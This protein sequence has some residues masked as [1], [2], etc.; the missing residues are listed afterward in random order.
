MI[1]SSKP[2]KSKAAEIRGSRD[3]PACILPSQD[4]VNSMR[5][6]EYTPYKEML[7]GVGLFSLEKRQIGGNL[8]PFYNY[9]KGG[10]DEVGVALFSHV[11]SNR[12]RGNGFK[13]RQEKFRLKKKKKFFPERVVR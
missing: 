2:C 12:K 6:L 11:T 10:C 5:C 9:L 1:P 8:I 4:T 13:L 7:R 3:T